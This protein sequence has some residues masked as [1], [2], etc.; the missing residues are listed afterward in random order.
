MEPYYEKI[1][2]FR[3]CRHHLRDAR[4]RR[5]KGWNAFGRRHESHGQSPDHGYQPAGYPFYINDGHCALNEFAAEHES[6]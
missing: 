1:F 5:E 3:V 4:L 6:T 2:V